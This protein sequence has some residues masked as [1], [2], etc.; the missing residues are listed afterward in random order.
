M[1]L[2]PPTRPR[3]AVLRRRPAH[4]GHAKDAGAPAR[5]AKVTPRA[6]GRGRARTPHHCIVAV[7]LT[8]CSSQAAVIASREIFLV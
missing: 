4:T 8:L 3:T 6:Q 7:A 5:S 2:C 1:T